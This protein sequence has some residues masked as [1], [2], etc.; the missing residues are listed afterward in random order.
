M[1]GAIHFGGEVEMEWKLALSDFLKSVSS[2]KKVTLPGAWATDVKALSSKSVWTD[3]T[4]SHTFNRL[5]E[6]A[7]DWRAKTPVL[8]ARISR[9]LEADKAGFFPET[10]GLT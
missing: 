6:I 5:E 2:P 7:S 8:G 1:D 3:G 4:E 9:V 10:F